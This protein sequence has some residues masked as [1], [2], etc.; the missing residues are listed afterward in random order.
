MGWGLET[1]LTV[2][3]GGNIGTATG[4]FSWRIAGRGRTRGDEIGEDSIVGAFRGLR[5]RP[6]VA[7]A[8]VRGTGLVKY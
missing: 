6:M 4:I 2:V 8:R 3:F 1:D 5:G 7:A